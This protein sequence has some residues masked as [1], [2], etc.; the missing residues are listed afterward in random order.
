MMI[1]GD[2]Y[3]IRG[4]RGQFSNGDTRTSSDMSHKQ[5]EWDKTV[6]K[7]SRN[8]SEKMKTMGKNSLKKTIWLQEE[9]QDSAQMSSNISQ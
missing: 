9:L 1:T 8:D 7:L 5:E 3:E 2:I 6:F 4:Y